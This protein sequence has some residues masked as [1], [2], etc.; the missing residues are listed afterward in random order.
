VHNLVYTSMVIYETHNVH[1]MRNFA[2][3]CVGCRKTVDG[4]EYMGGISTTVGG[5]EC[6][7]WTATTPHVPYHTVTDDKFPDGSRAAA[8]NYCRNWGEGSRGPWCYTM[9]PNKRFEQCDVPLCGGIGK[10]RRC[11]AFL[12]AEI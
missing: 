6:Q 10:C 4:Q 5:L 12:L 1:N 7:A 8:K 9:D 2:C 3:N 11:I